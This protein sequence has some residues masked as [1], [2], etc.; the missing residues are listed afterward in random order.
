MPNRPSTEVPCVHV[1]SLFGLVVRNPQN[2][3]W[4]NL[5]HAEEAQH[6]G[7]LET[8]VIFLFR[9]LHSVYISGPKSVQ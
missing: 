2:R 7:A 4:P 9:R 6:R 5:V 8:G 1:G 3:L